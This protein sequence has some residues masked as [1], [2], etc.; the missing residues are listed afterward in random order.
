MLL[1]FF[2][3][4][5]QKTAY[6][7][8]RSLVGSEMCIRDRRRVRGITSNS[9][10]TRLV[11][12]LRRPLI[13][14]TAMPLCTASVSSCNPLEGANTIAAEV[15]SGHANVMTV[16][17]DTPGRVSRK[18]VGKE[19]TEAS[20][21]V[22]VVLTGGPCG[23]KSSA[24]KQ[25]SEVATANGFD[26]Y[27]IPE[28][29][30]LF[31]GNGVK[32]MPSDAFKLQFTRSILQLQIQLER[33]FTRIAGATGRPTILVC[34]RGTIDNKGYCSPEVWD[35]SVKFVNKKDGTANVSEEYMVGRYDLVVH[36]VTSADGAEEF[37]KFGWQTDDN[38]NKVYRSETPE[39]ARELDAKMIEVWKDHPRHVV[40]KNGQ[41][42]KEK[43]NQASDAIME[44]AFSKHPQHPQGNDKWS[45]HSHPM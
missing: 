28:C 27:L 13:A 30:T 26:L 41:G 36:L 44:V 19:D 39:Q 4:F 32:Y 37:Y 18:H 14:A 25:L 35:R 23:G 8:L 22:R 2:F 20:S 31:F 38:G 21:V 7:M 5:K 29:A 9:M 24:L 16:L 17:A 43:L 11:T 45:V 3:F 1:V 33:S 42:F 10:F 40:V 34:D 15:P 6:E 12:N